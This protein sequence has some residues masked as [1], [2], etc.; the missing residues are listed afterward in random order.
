MR[1]PSTSTNPTTDLLAPTDTPG[2]GTTASV[3]PVTR[4]AIDRGVLV[5][6]F[7]ALLAAGFLLAGPGGLMG[8]GSPWADA[9]AAAHA[10]HSLELHRWHATE[11]AVMIALVISGTLLTS[12]WRPRTQRLLTQSALLGIGLFGLI[13]FAMPAPLEV[14]VPVLAVLILVTAASPERRSLLR[15]TPA[16]GR[17]PIALGAALAA[18]PFLL[19]TVW[20]NLARQVSDGG[21]HA[22]LGHWAVAAVLAATLLILGWLATRDTAG[23]PLLSAVLGASYLYLGVAALVLPRHDG[24]WSTIGGLIALALGVACLGS[25]LQRT[26]SPQLD[27]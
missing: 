6:R 23:A 3:E 4:R 21:E 11:I 24:S 16:T 10:G 20:Q 1:R 7:V 26:V 15:L 14:L 12:A 13:A 5:Y 25:V 18:T 9:T 2:G 17:R 8:L 19:V 27:R 22:E